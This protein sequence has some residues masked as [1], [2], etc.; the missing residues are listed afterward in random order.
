MES[1]PAPVRVAR[2]LHV[3]ALV[4]VEPDGFGSDASVVQRFYAKGADDGQRLRPVVPPV[5]SGYPR[6]LHLREPLPP[7]RAP[8]APH[9]RVP[10]AT[11]GRSGVAASGDALR[12]VG[13]GLVLSQWNSLAP[14]KYS[15]ITALTAESMVITSDLLAF[16]RN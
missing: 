13:A 12:T 6:G 1:F 14:N 16:R 3:L 11:D 15:V 5:R 8:L 7:V 9:R 10:R 2:A 4:G